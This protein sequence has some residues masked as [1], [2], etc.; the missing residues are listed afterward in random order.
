MNRGKRVLGTKL[1]T[2]IAF[3]MASALIFAAMPSWAEDDISKPDILVLEAQKT[4]KDFVNDPDLPWVRDNL[5]KAKAVMIVPRLLKAGFIIGGTGGSGLLVGL[6]DKGVWSYP[7][8][9]TMGSVT[10][11]LQIGGAA[12]QVVLM[13]MTKKGMD[14]MLTS[15]FK[16][17][18][19][20]SVAAGPV[21]TGAK[22]ATVDILA[23]SRSKGVFGGIT[24]EGAVIATRDEWN[25]QYYGKSVLPSDILVLRNVSNAQADGLRATLHKA[26]N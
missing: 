13:V 20:A 18:G 1:G 7:A 2:L 6:N 19:E 3:V 14:A 22:G 21:G 25:S 16:L 26:T 24:I 11:G 8:F 9:Y 12:D 15:S 10:F 17:G 4:I 23:F 5:K